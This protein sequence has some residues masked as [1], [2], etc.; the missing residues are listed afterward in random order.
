MKSI[1]PQFLSKLLD[2]W[3]SVPDGPDVSTLVESLRNRNFTQPIIIGHDS[4]GLF[5]QA[6]EIRKKTTKDIDV[7]IPGLELFLN[8]LKK[9]PKDDVVCVA[10]VKIE[11]VVFSIYWTK[12]D[13]IIRGI[14]VIKSR[15]SLNLEKWLNIE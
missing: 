7:I 2:S 13:A 6:F 3:P 14:L 1:S 8:E 10:H 5:L 9:L 15:Q 11:G 12:L 4:A